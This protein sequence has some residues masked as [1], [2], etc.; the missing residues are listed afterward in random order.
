MEETLRGVEALAALGCHP[1]LSPFRPAA[2]TRLAGQPPPSAAFLSEVLDRSRAIVA[3]H[4]VRL[5]PD[6]V[7]CQ[8]NTLAFPWDLE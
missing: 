6:C 4:G 7:P 3:R 5:G 1:T 2:G 8:H